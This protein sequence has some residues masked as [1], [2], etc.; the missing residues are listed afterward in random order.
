M[1][2]NVIKYRND[3]KELFKNYGLHRAIRSNSLNNLVD[4]INIYYQERETPVDKVIKELD[5]FHEEHLK[6][7]LTGW[8]KYLDSEYKKL[9]KNPPEGDGNTAYGKGVIKGFGMVIQKL[10]DVTER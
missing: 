1:D 5:E 2:K 9:V 8:I 10:K 6:E 3:L 4:E 7:Q